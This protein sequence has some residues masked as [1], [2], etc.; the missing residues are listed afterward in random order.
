MLKLIALLLILLVLFAFGAY[1]WG[2]SLPKEHVAEGTQQVAAAPEQVAA[3]LR[4]VEAYP[5]WRRGIVRIEILGRTPDV[6]RYREHGA[7]DSIA[8][9]WRELEPSRNFET[10][11]DDPAQPFGGRWLI[12]L[13]PGADGTNVTIREEGFVNPPIYRLMSRYV[14]G[15][16]KSLKDYLAD[17]AAYAQLSEQHRVK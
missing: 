12:S 9:R 4:D 11:I 17:L 3:W 7:H 14:F 8:Y 16:D 2:A 1:M 13:A 5:R 10:T 6:L 15:L